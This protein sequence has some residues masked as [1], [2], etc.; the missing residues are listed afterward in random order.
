[1]RS[2]DSL[3][4]FDLFRLASALAVAVGHCWTIYND[5]EVLT[6]GTMR[7]GRSGV[8]ILCAIGGYFAFLS[9]KGPSLPW[10]WKRLARVYPPFWATVTILVLANHWFHQ[11][12]VSLGL[13]VSEYAGIGFFTHGYILGVHLWF[14]SLILVCYVGAALIRKHVWLM[15]FV[16]APLVFMEA[17]VAELALCFLLGGAT[18]VTRSWWPPALGIAS[19]ILLGIEFNPDFR[20]LAIAGLAM[21][22]APRST[23]KSPPW[24]ASSAQASYEFYLLHPIAYLFLKEVVGLGYW[25]NL[26]VGTLAT[27]VG[28]PLLQWSIEYIEFWAACLVQ[29]M[30]RR[31]T[32]VEQPVP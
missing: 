8:A 15:P 31:P 17:D 10:L 16:A 3:L 13:I 18:A 22:L 4:V 21:L 6:V 11:R 14:I 1:M 5:F 26:V 7:V 30:C 19:G 29:L 23:A 27:I 20:Y 12:P 32:P 25:T 28:V 24:I 9:R 2:R